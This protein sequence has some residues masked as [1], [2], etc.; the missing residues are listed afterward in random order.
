MTTIDT[1]MVL[2]RLAEAAGGS[3]RAGGPGDHVG[4]MPC[5]WVVGPRDTAQVGAVMRVAHEAGLAV[6]P[7]GAGTKLGWGPPP[8]RLDVLLDLT[9]LDALV[10]HAAGDLITIVGAGRLLEDLQRDLSGSGQWLAVDP[11]RSGTVG[12]LVATAS[13]GPTR[14]LH[15]AVR[16]LVI[17]TTM[18]RADGVVSHSGGKVVKNVAGYDLGKLLTGSF[19]TLGVLT[20]VAFRLHPVA[21]ASGWVTVPV[22][23]ARHATALAQGVLHSH[24]VAT[25]CELERPADGAASLAIRLDGIAAGVAART[26]DALEL[27]G[28]GAEALDEAPS[29]WGTDP[30]RPGDV[31]LK[32][33]H[34]TASLTALLDAVDEAAERWAVPVDVRGSV[35]VG[36]VSAALRGSHD[37]AA[38]V[39]AVDQLRSAATTFGGTV[40]VL[41]A[42]PETQR[43]LDVWGP[44]KGLDLM[45]RV[46]DQFDPDRVLS[47]GR[48]V[49]GI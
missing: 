43:M 38:T 47:P 32:L 33:T 11:P 35:A 17:G 13:T 8:E 9:G 14:L 40:V 46:K 10:E 18:V 41:D 15:G 19:G 45:R 6:V 16:D 3:A 44:V 23:S 49:G 5:R 42:D 34:E 39:S 7:R 12:G 21:E 28:G 25:A 37:R 26:A 31:L 27:F 20:E 30:G 48:F 29:W 1:E 22:T 36:T 4:G 24:L 2:S